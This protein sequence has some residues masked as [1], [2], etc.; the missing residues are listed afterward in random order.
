MP[1]EQP[2][3]RFKDNPLSQ[4]GSFSDPRRVAPEPGYFRTCYALAL[5]QAREFVA[6]VDPEPGSAVVEVG[7][8]SGRVTCHGGLA[9]RIGRQGR[10]L[11]TDPFGARFTYP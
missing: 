10:L 7:A 6:F 2:F 5:E 11:V 3:L 9:E 8:V 1:H 4:M